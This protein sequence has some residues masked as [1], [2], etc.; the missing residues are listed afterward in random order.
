MT[1]M[2]WLHGLFIG[3]LTWWLLRRVMKTTQALIGALGMALI[4]VALPILLVQEKELNFNAALTF[5]FGAVI[6]VIAFIWPWLHLKITPPLAAGI[7]RY[8][9]DACTWLAIVA[10]IWLY[11]A[12]LSIVLMI[13]RNEFKTIVKEDIVP[14]RNALER[15]V[16]PR[17]LSEEQK[18]TIGN[19]LSKFR[20]YKAA[21]TVPTRDAEAVSYQN[22][23]K[24]ALVAGGWK[25][26]SGRTDLD[27]VEE[28]LTYDFIQTPE[29]FHRDDNDPRNPKQNKLFSDALAKAKVDVIGGANHQAKA[30]EEEILIIHIGHRKRDRKAGLEFWPY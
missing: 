16:I 3:F 26:S 19:Y 23:I 30:G 4:S 18:E 14:I 11:G 15:W 5:I 29:T 20:P 21:F 10:T 6:L 24:E 2:D 9:S 8:A 7:T 13:Q 1:G 22:D 17:N 25:I 28:G 27:D 12:V